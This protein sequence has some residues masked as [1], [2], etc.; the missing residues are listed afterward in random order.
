MLSIPLGFLLIATL[1]LDALLSKIDFQTTP[2]LGSI[3]VT[4]KNKTQIG[5]LYE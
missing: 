2:D 5:G 4:S 1:Y 3:V